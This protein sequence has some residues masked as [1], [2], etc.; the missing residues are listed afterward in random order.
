M[1]MDVTHP[2]FPEQS[3]PPEPEELPLPVQQHPGD[4]PKKTAATKRSVTRA[5]AKAKAESS[6][7]AENATDPYAPEKPVLTVALFHANEMGRAQKYNPSKGG[8]QS[9]DSDD[10]F[11]GMA[12]VDLTQL[13]TGKLRTFDQWLPLSGTDSE[14]ASVRIV[15]EYESADAPP[16]RGDLVRFTKFCHAADLYP[17]QH[18][19]LYTVDEC[20]HDN[21]LLSI[22]SP[23]GW[24]SSF[25]VHRYM[26]VCEE[27]HQG[28][29]DFYH[30]EFASIAERLAHS[31]LVSTVQGTVQRVPD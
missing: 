16:Q 8:S 11:L 2:A 21:V 9:G 28:A 31:P 24:V 12:V 30:D 6:A 13:L 4:P 26:V 10:V 3:P 1:Y 5:V 23:E 22:T 25:V 17:A 19:R 18:D 14:R 29:A 20:D 27:R 15:A 7:I